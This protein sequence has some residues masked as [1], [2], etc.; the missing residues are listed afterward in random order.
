MNIAPK[1]VTNNVP[2]TKVGVMMHLA[3]RTTLTDETSIQELASTSEEC[4]QRGD[5]HLVIDLSSVQVVNSAA[6]EMLM[7]IH[8]R[9]IRMGGWV[10]LTRANPIIQDILLLTQFTRYISL[11][12]KKTPPHISQLPT[13]ERLGDILVSKGLLTEKRVNEAIELQ[14]KTSRRI[15]Q[16]IIDKGWASENDVLTALSEQLLYH[17]CDCAP[18]STTRLWPCWSKRPLRIAYE[19]CHCKEY[20]IRFTLQPEIPRQ[21]RHSTKYS[22]IQASGYNLCWHA[23]RK[24][25]D[26]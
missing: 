16:I 8:D 22:S 13:Q 17:M 23:A 25:R 11:L 12:D 3:P 20:G 6:L 9:A 21:S 10:K 4:L 5:T 7:S 19:F 18:A 26:A 1:D 24:Y 14:K 15:G 2:S